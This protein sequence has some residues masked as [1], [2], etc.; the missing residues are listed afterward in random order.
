MVCLCVYALS[1][2]FCRS[3]SSIRRFIDNSANVVACVKL[4]LLKQ[5]FDYSYEWRSH[6]QAIH[7]RFCTPTT[8]IDHSL[9]HSVVIAYSWFSAIKINLVTDTA[10]A[11]AATVAVAVIASTH[12]HIHTS[13]NH[14]NIGFFT[15]FQAC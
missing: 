15:T 6:L 4:I 3:L 10:D 8:N 13:T 9:S 5:F 14:I 12:S 1:V 11:A 7:G 2:L